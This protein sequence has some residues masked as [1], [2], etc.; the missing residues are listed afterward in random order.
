MSTDKPGHEVDGPELHPGTP[1]YDTGYAE[2][3][4]WLAEGDGR[5][6][7]RSEPTGNWDG[8]ASW[9]GTGI[10]G[11]KEPEYCDVA[12]AV[13]ETARTASYPGGHPGRDVSADAIAADRTTLMYG[14]ALARQ[15]AAQH[16][17]DH[18]REAG[19]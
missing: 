12:A 10:F 17:A 2:Y 16:Q 7:G 6:G 14:R 1:E 5:D 11:P 13:R 9:G 3:K 18:D 8:N 19:A 15:Y 4:T